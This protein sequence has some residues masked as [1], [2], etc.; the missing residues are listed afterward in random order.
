MFKPILI[1]KL[2][3]HSLSCIKGQFLNTTIKL[4]V[5][6]IYLVIIDSNTVPSDQ[7]NLILPCGLCLEWKILS[8][9]KKG[10]RTKVYIG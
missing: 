7:T 6:T 4:I 2:S 8:R 9:G 10:I 3:P 1:H 5:T